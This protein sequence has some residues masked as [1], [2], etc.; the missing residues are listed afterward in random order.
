[1]GRKKRIPSDN[2]CI[3][4]GR[5]TNDKKFPGEDWTNKFFVCNPCE[6]VWCANCMGQV[7]GLGVSKTHK[8]GKK[9]RVNCPNCGNMAVMIKLPQNLPFKQVKATSE[10]KQSEFC[11][12]CGE[13]LKKDKSKCSNC[14]ADQ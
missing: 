1:M 4:C 8:M 3:I 7:S 10:P 9:G 6:K 12:F 13:K 11:R 14:G 5:N 2:Y